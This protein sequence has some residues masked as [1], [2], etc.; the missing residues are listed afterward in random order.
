MKNFKN[1]IIVEKENVVEN[2]KLFKTEEKR[3]LKNIG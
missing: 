1:K 2:N 3:N